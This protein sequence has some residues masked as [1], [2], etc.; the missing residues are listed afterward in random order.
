[1]IAMA[2]GIPM[3]WAWGVAG[4]VWSIALSETL[5]FVAAVVLLRRKTREFASAAPSFLVMSASK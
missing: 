2:A 4:A 3:T 5:A 1:V